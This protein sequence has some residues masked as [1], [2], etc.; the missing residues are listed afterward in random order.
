MNESRSISAGAP[1][2]SAFRRFLVSFLA[3]IGTLA[4]FIVVSVATSRNWFHDG[5]DTAVAR[6]FS[7]PWEWSFFI[8]A[9]SRA[10][11]WVYL[12]IVAILP[13]T[14]Y[15]LFYFALFS[16]ISAFRSSRPHQLDR[17]A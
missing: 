10:T 5:A 4:F 1:R 7:L 3:A 15:M 6:W 14:A 9:S 17:N 8:A 2:Y 16:A 12:S 11:G 13:L